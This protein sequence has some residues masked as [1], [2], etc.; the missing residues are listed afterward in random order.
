MATH[1]NNLL[2]V[3]GACAACIIVTVTAVRAVSPEEAWAAGSLMG[4][5]SPNHTSPRVKLSADMNTDLG[6][7]DLETVQTL[8]IN[9]DGRR[10]LLVRYQAP[11]ISDELQL[12][13]AKQILQTVQGDAI[14]AGI[15][16]VVVSAV[17]PSVDG[18]P[19]TEDEEHILMFENTGGM[20]VQMKDPGN[21]TLPRFNTNAPTPATPP[22]G[23][24]SPLVIEH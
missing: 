10:G 20:W 8:P 22:A 1:S 13:V 9:V 3:A 12:G 24:G 17:P 21:G 11:V 4:D 16:V 23:S 14:A 7:D 2:Y 6:D 5:D 15:E 19:A 18:K